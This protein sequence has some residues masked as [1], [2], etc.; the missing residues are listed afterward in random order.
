[1]S[2]ARRILAVTAGLIVGGALF[3]A[4]AAIATLV[5]GLAVSGGLEALDL[6][7]LQLVGG[8]GAVLGGV[9]FPAAAWLLMRTVP[10]G[11]ALLGTVAGTV[12]GGAAGWLLAA[13]EFGQVVHV[14][15]GGVIG[16]VAAS[17]LLRIRAGRAPRVRQRVSPG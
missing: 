8:V 9:L 7:A 12:A 6:R 17:V 14:L 1:M 11:L 15:I 13:S 10:I 16:F 2:Q 4:V 3:G 5:I